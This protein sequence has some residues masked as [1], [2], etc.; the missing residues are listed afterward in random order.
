MNSTY[1]W[2]GSLVRVNL[3]SGEN[4]RIST[5]ELTERFIGGRGVVSKIYWDEVDQKTDALHPENP[6]ILMTGPLAGTPA[7]SANR[8]FMAGKSPLLYPDQFGLGSIG[9]SMAV[10]IKAAGLDGIV[11]TGRAQKPSYLHITNGTVEIK[12]ASGLWGCEIPDTLKR[13]GDEHG[14]N[15][16]S[17]CIGPAG[18]NKVRFAIA[19]SDNGSCGG[20]GF[21][22]VMG[23][24]NLKAI[25]VE[26][27]EKVAVA[28]PD[29]LKKINSQIRSLIEGRVLMD[30]NLDGI[31]L[32]KRSPCQGCPSG[33]ARGLYK[34]VSGRE[35]IRKN[36]G[37]AYMYYLWDRMQNKDESTPVAFLATSLIDRFGLCAQEM[38][39]LL[40]WLH[41]CEEKGIITDDKAG[42]TLSQLGTQEFI[43]QLIDMIVYRKGFGDLLAEGPGRAA[44][45]L[46]KAAEEIYNLRATRS[47]FNAGA[48]NPRFFITNAV[49]YATESTSTMNQ[50]HEVCFPIM[51]WT[52][53]YATDGGMSP[54]S[55]EVMQNIARRFWKSEKA[56]DFSTYEG[57]SEVAYIIQ[58]R[59]YAKENLVVCDFM[60]PITTAEGAS[61]HVGDP[62]IESRLL[63]S[64]TG[65]DFSETAYYQTG[66]RVFNLQ[67]A[68]QGREG[69]VGRK[70][71]CLNEFNFTQTF[72]EEPGFFA[73]FNP[74][75]MLP[76]PGGELMSRKGKVVEREQFEK[77]M[78]DYYSLR[79][80]DV[81]S[82]LQTRKTLET[83]SLSDILPEMEKRGLLS[84]E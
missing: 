46:G 60:Y 66:E 47:G 4:Q 10:K 54:F 30:P 81:K 77:M 15:A 35:E 45:A 39:N 41:E 50:L 5:A 1:G 52:M 34:H 21:G 37:S 71:D 27:T 20:S 36:C 63:S 55:T 23:S 53:W 17:V 2:K 16:Q 48:Y 75:Y 72:E 13:L 28:R 24:K 82:G 3:T 42:I 73:V 14:K 29:E 38:N 11:V 84:E 32:I 69:R 56:V 74:D 26:G 31:E 40:H 64:V 25:V 83:L 7:I 79:G 78:D 59:Q 62:T 12:D 57:K 43:E 18:E 8:W 70:D 6:L 51:K 58:N 49:F 22:A 9:G 76:G 80:W 67:R 44:Q 19:M 33:C 68:I 61:D 65:I